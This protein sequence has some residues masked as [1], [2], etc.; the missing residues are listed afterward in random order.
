MVSRNRAKWDLHRSMQPDFSVARN[1]SCNPNWAG[2]IL[3]LRDLCS[4]CMVNSQIAYTEIL[5]LMLYPFLHWIAS[6]L[7][8][9]VHIY[10]Y[11]MGKSMVVVSCGFSL[12]QIHWVIVLY[13]VL[14]WPTLTWVLVMDS[15]GKVTICR[16]MTVRIWR[17][18]TFGTLRCFPQLN[19]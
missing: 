3:F 5:A 15:C 10:P 13:E 7:R 18:S 8:R 19:L 11:F 4:S 14:A 6:K 16:S 9:K 12:T 1:V 2:E 17:C